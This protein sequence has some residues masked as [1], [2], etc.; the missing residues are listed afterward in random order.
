MKISPSY[1][2]QL[3]AANEDDAIEALSHLAGFWSARARLSETGELIGLSPS[4]RAAH[5]ALCYSGE[6][7]N[8]G[9]TQY[10][11]NLWGSFA[12]E[13]VDS[14]ETLGLEEA[15]SI[16]GDAIQVFPDQHVPKERTARLA[17][18]K[19]L[20]RHHLDLLHR[21]DSALGAI[22]MQFDMQI[23]GYLQQHRHDVLAAEQS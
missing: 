18:L 1:V 3:L 22:A 21:A 5:L 11:M 13:T 23:L 10:F 16:L 14:L 17:A 2:A 19:N 6:V 12:R 15:A 4:E 9:H 20:G 7:G 8:G